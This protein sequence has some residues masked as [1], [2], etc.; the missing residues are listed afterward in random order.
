MFKKI[1]TIL[2]ALFF[3]N[4]LVAQEGRYG[5]S[6][7]NEQISGS[8]LCVDIE[9]RFKEGGKLGSSN[10]VMEYNKETLTNPVLVSN[11]LPAANYAT[12]T[13]FQSV[14][15]L[16]SFNIDL[17]IENAGMTIAE[18]PNKTVLGNVCFDILAGSGASFLDWKIKNTTATVVYLDDD[19]SKLK[20]GKI[21]VL[22]N[23]EGNPCDDRNAN[24][25]DDKLDSN[26]NCTGTQ[27]NCTDD[28]VLDE[29]TIPS[30]TYKSR[31]KIRSAGFV[32]NNSSVAFKAGESITLS[33]GFEA[34]E[35]CDFLA[36][37]ELC[38][39]NIIEEVAENRTHKIAKSA[40][41]LGD[42]SLSIQPNPVSTSATIIYTLPQ[43]QEI[44]INIYSL[45][46]HLVKRIESAMMSEG[47]HLK[48]WNAQDLSSGM[49]LLTL[50]TRTHQEVRKIIIG[51]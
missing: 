30:R 51:N 2:I 34:E 40:T 17:L 1:N 18:A 14:D 3:L 4:S 24:T 27:M 20:R 36:M 47:M 28:E 29:E 48:E 10:L 46:G 11:N 21:E 23:N 49:Y 43:T 9:L 15:S 31:M 19:L 38:E 26:C 50:E 25:S 44:A 41:N 13:F 12:P 7:G 37:I 32:R 33:E 22:C 35:G 6:F 5:L 45:Q 42:F 16:A 8:T 39:D